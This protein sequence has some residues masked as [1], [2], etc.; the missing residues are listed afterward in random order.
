MPQQV[1]DLLLMI[2]NFQAL[3]LEIEAL[4]TIIAQVNSSLHK[5]TSKSNLYSDEV[6]QFTILIDASRKLTADKK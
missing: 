2:R 3:L 4:S 1:M 5:E 6:L